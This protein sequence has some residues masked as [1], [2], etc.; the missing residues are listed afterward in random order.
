MSTDASILRGMNAMAM[1]REITYVSV[2]EAAEFLQVTPRRVH[3]FIDDGRLPAKRLNNR[4]AL[5]SMQD[6]EEFRNQPRFSG[7]KGHRKK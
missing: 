3:Q 2:S 5:L 7:G 1:D 4:F 6:L